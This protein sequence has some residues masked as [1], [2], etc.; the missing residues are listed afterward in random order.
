MLRSASVLDISH[1]NS[2]SFH[3]SFSAMD[4]QQP[5]LSQLASLAGVQNDATQEHQQQQQQPQPHMQQQ[6]DQSV[7]ET[8]MNMGMGNGMGDGNMGNSVLNDNSGGSSN[9]SGMIP[10]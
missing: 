8:G 5:N 3:F 7:S 6:M 10:F 1:T 4:H 9:S 2:L